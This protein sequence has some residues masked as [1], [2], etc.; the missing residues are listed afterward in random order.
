MQF[1]ASRLHNAFG[2]DIIACQGK[3]GLAIIV[4]I[5]HVLVFFLQGS[6]GIIRH[7][8]FVMNGHFGPF[9]PPW[10]VELLERRFVWVVVVVVEFVNTLHLYCCVVVLDIPVRNIAPPACIQNS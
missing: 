6:I 7:G 2:N 1:S 4:H 8:K 3:L 10:M 5:F 9:P